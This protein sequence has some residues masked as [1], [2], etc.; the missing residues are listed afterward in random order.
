MFA[1]VMEFATWL[2]D[3]L[4]SKRK[5]YHGRHWTDTVDTVESDYHPMP[6]LCAYPG[7]WQARCEGRFD[8]LRVPLKTLNVLIRIGSE[9]DRMI[10]L[11]NYR[12]NNVPMT[13]WP[14]SW[15]AIA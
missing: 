5:T 2:A 7:L 14:E 4:F 9:V 15:R 11:R 6:E 1:V 8:Y 13:E 12:W 3:F 10:S